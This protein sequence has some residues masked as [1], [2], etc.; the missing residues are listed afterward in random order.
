VLA[1]AGE[2]FHLV[3]HSYGAAVAAKAALAMPGR[4]VSLTLY[5][6]TLFGLLE[7]EAPGGRAA[8]GIADTAAAAAAAIDRGDLHAA[9][10]VFLDYWMGPGTWAATPEARRATVAEAMRPIRGWAEAVFNE[11]T[12]LSAFGALQLPVLLMSGA[13][14]PA[15]AHG[16]VRLLA[17]ALPRVQRLDLPGIGHMGPVTH[18][19]VVNP[20]I[21]RFLWEA[22]ADAAVS[23]A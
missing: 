10:G 3:G 2:R 22:A 7:Q 19:D 6:P 18:P 21:E 1:A 13:T 9:A 11:P 17:S 23:A 8:A 20:H 4:V 12:P 14:S 15:S 16:V 5:E